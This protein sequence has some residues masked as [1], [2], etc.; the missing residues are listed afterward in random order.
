[1]RAR[2]LMS[3]P[4]YTCHVNDPLNVAAQLMWDHDCGALPV[5]NDDGKLVGMITDRD[6]CMSAYTRGEALDA[7]L[8]NGAMSKH[9]IAARADQP[10]AELEELMARH[11]VRRLP[12]INSEGEPVGLISLNDIALEAAQPDTKMHNGIPKVAYTL[13]AICEHPRA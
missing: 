11:K 9:I 12:V 1:M 10:I 4:V 3:A 7:L 13:A 8:V 5:V 2:D 6:I